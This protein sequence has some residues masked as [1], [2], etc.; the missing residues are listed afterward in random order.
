MNQSTKER[1]LSELTHFPD[2]FL[3]GQQLADTLEVSRTAVWKAIRSLKEDGFDIAAVTNRGYRLITAPLPPDTEAVE[4]QFRALGHPLKVS[5]YPTLDSTNEEAK[6]LAAVSSEDRLIIAGS[7]TAGRGRRGRTFCS[8]ADTGLYM[9]LLLHPGMKLAK[10]T[11]VTAITAAAVAKAIDLTAFSGEDRTKIKWVNDIFLNERK[12]CGIL[13]EACSPLEDEDEGY[14]IIGIGINL[15]EPKD[16]FPKELNG[17]AGA[18][19][20]SDAETVPNIK[21]LLA[22]QIVTAFYTYFSHSAEA[23]SVYRRKS[24]LI[25]AYVKINAFTELPKNRRYAYVTGITSRCRLAIR[26]E[27]GTDDELASGEVSVIRY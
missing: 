25:G 21:T 15:R 1:V 8:P 11:T 7:Q 10:L 14:L 4:R 22:V 5:Y 13:T 27:D 20:R 6:R 2:T 9:S 23:L 18:V 17:I 12:V 3:S 16:G 26:Y 19:F 24:N